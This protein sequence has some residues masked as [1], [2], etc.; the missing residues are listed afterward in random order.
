MCLLTAAGV[1]WPLT[2]LLTIS[3][4]VKDAALGRQNPQVC[5]KVSRKP[6]W[7]CLKKPGAERGKLM[8]ETEGQLYRMTE[9]GVIKRD[10]WFGSQLP[11][12]LQCSCNIYASQQG[13]LYYCRC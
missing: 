6:A 4:V 13:S 9:G 3:A 7:L 2:G 8:A 12:Q 1:E 11:L 5:T 10:L